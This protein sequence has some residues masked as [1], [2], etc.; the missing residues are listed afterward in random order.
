MSYLRRFILM[1]LFIIPL[2]LAL[3]WLLNTIRSNYTE[4]M[5]IAY[6]TGT[7]VVVMLTGI[8]GYILYKQHRLL[9]IIPFIL[10]SLSLIMMTAS[11]FLESRY[12][13]CLTT[14]SIAIIIGLSAITTAIVIPVLELIRSRQRFS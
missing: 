13:G 11:E 9:L 7:V 5:S 1:A 2:T 8:L 4:Y 12:A 6:L 10:A 14:M 3:T